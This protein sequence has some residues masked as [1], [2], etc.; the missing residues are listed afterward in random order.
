MLLF[1]LI[2]WHS[3]DRALAI[4]EELDNFQ[5]KVPSEIHTCDNITLP[6]ATL[7]GRRPC[8]N[9]RNKDA[10]SDRRKIC[11]LLSHLCC[12]VLIQLQHLD[13]YE[14]SDHTASL[15]K[16]F[17]DVLGGVYGNGKA[18]TVCT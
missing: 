4:S 7:A 10:L 14:W 13:A 18:D 2:D 9:M 8:C 15:L 16:L 17:N 11:I 6:H 3:L 5:P 12:I 1:P